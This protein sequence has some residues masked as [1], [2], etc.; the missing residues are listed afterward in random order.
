MELRQLKNRAEIIGLLK[1]MNIEEKT[2]RNGKEMLIGNA[3][4]EVKDGEKVN[5]IRVNV[6]QMKH[7]KNGEIMKPFKSLQTVIAEYKT[8]DHDGRENADLVRVNGEYSLNEYYTDEGEFRSTKQIRASYFK[9]L[10]EEA[11]HHALLTTDLVVTNIENEVDSEGLVTG[12]LKVEGFTV[13]YGPKVTPLKD[14]IVNEDLADAFR[15]LYFEG[16]TGLV[17]I[18]INSFAETEIVEVESAPSHGFGA[19][20]KV[21]ENIITNY[22]NEYIIIGGDVPYQGT[23]EYTPEEIE[24]AKKARALDLSTMKA[25]SSAPAQ[26]TGFGAKTPSQSEID[27]A[28]DKI[29]DAHEKSTE[30]TIVDDMPD[31]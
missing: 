12:R 29:L 11:Q 26:P 7:K 30:N 2:S 22:I 19:T 25:N 9:R 20:A 17:T 6:L 18:Q 5:N 28:V 23:A 24:E 14:L 21:E 27:S 15:S 1:S 16:V 4:I 3:V 31:F 13:N 8:I 10:D